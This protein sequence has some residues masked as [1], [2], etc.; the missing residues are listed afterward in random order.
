M[1]D[2]P[3]DVL[4]KNWSMFLES[5]PQF[6][7]MMWNWVTLIQ[8]LLKRTPL[9]DGDDLGFLICGFMAASVVDLNDILTLIHANSR[10][11]APKLLRSLYERTVTMKYLAEHP[12]EVEKF[13]G[14]Q[15]IDWKQVIDVC[16][17]KI[18]T[19][20]DEPART[21]LANAATDAR[22]EYK[23]EVCPQCK[24][25]K[26]TNW[27]P[28]SVKELADIAGLSHLHAH[29]YI[30]PSK[31]MHPTFWGMIDFM[32]QGSPIYNVLNCAHELLVHNV[33]IHRRHFAKNA[34][35]T[36]MMLTA[37]RDFLSIWVFSETSFGDLL[38]KGQIRDHG[39]RIYY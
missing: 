7:S 3:Q 34:Q 16:Q 39:N 23:G 8:N 14:F 17:G 26:Q 24:Q 29:S 25:R 35:P 38:R 20:L 31:T 19:E 12:G 27:T 28:K 13:I 30:F 11:G 2:D 6:P 33:L 4:P 9:G 18:G 21:R 22:K 32:K 37:I 10:S 5:H 15:S 36:P 1:P